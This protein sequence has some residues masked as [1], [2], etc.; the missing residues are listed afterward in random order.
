RMNEYLPLLEGKRVAMVVNHTAVI[1]STHIVDTLLSRG[2][3]IVKVFAPE[4]GFRGEADAGQKIDDGKDA[5]TGVTITSLYGKTRKPT[6]QMLEDVDVIIF[7]IQD[8][9]VRF[10]TYI[11]TMHHTMDGAAEHNKEYIVLDRPNPNGNYVD[12]PIREEGLESFVG[13]HPIPIVH[14]LTV[15][16]LAEMINGEGWLANG[17]QCNLK[18]IRTLN[19][20]HADEW[21]LPIKPSPN[22]PNDVSIA[23]Y[24]SICFF[25]GT[26][27]SLG[28][29]TYKPFQQVGDPSLKGQYE[30][31]FTPI[32]IPGMATKPKH[33]DEVCYG[34]DYST[35]E[36]KRE[37]TLKYLIEFYNAF[38]NK[39]DFFNGYIDKLAG[40]TQLK[41]QIKQGI[42]E[43]DIRKTW[44]P[45]LS[46]YKEIRKKYLLYPEQ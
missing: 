14:G 5:K 43:E 7:D 41:E 44:E 19:Y 38:E 22:L 23:L 16:E 3:N 31:T 17:A 35:L 33:M 12:G 6:A 8:V 27:L 20:T 36:I 39:N 15:G 32:S 11:S 9:G 29:G 30:Y 37:F 10:Y 34:M 46:D 42:S 21:S 26:T 45:A 24:P 13:I 25:E 18:V 4:H 2:V 28:R 40:T 1:G